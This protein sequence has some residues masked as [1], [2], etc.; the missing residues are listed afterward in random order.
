MTKVTL[1]QTK[2]EK[3]SV[4]RNIHLEGAKESKWVQ[5]ATVVPFPKSSNLYLTIIPRQPEKEEPTKAHVIRVS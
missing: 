2:R 4:T 5:L 1:K 3:G